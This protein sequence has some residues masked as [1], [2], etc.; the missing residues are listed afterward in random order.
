MSPSLEAPS[1]REKSQVARPQQSSKFEG[2][3]NNSSSVHPVRIMEDDN[4]DYDSNASSSSFEFHRGERSAAQGQISRAI[5]RPVPSKWNDAEKW[6]VSRQNHSHNHPKRNALQN[7]TNRMSVGNNMGK[8]APDSGGCDG[9]SSLS[10][11]RVDFCQ[12]GATQIGFDRFSFEPA[13]IR[14]RDLEEPGDMASSDGLAAEEST[15]LLT[16]S[17]LKQGFIAILPVL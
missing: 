8:V 4:L 14:T 10:L 11:K 16:H 5:S 12:S 17:E 13:A 9:R 7:Q 2:V 1:S 3:G 6:L 15:G